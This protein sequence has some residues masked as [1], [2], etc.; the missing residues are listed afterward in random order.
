MVIETACSGALIAILNACNAMKQGQCDAAIVAGANILTHPN[1]SKIFNGLSMTSPTGYCKP[2]DDE[3]NGFVRSEAAEVIILQRECDAKRI[4]A[5][6]VHIAS[7]SDGFK[8]E[9]Y[10]YP[11][12]YRQKELFENFYNEINLNPNEVDYI[13]MHG[14]GTKAGDPVECWAVDQVFNQKR[15]KPLLIGS[16]KSNMGHTENF[17]AGASIAKAIFTFENGLIPPSIHFKTPNKN[18]PSL[19][20]GKLKVCTEITPLS[21]QY[22]AIN[23]FGFGGVNGHLLLK[24]SSKMKVNK[25]SPNDELPRL[26]LWSGR[27]KEAVKKMF[28]HIC[29]ETLDA[30]FVGLTHEI[31]KLPVY[32]HMNRGYGIF[33]NT[34]P[35][36][37][38]ISLEQH[39][40]KFDDIKRPIVWMLTG[41]GS[42]W[43]GMINGLMKIR[44]FR[45]TI[46]KCHKVLMEHNY[47]LISILEST[48]IDVINDIINSMVSIT[49]IE[50]GLIEILKMLN[51]P[52]DFVIGH[53]LGEVAVGYADESF[54]LEQTILCSYFR[55]LCSKK[56]QL[57]DGRM[58][59]IG[60][61]YND[62]KNLLPDR[63]YCACRNSSTSST[64][65]G[66]KS[67]IEKFVAELHSKKIFAK[68]VNTNNIA[69]HSKYIQ[70]IAELF[71]PK[72]K[73]IIPEPKKRSSKWLSTCYAQNEW[74]KPCA[75][76]L[77]AEYQV[78]NLL[79]TVL[80]EDILK[81]LP[82]DAIII[83][84]A[85]CG[86]LQA[87]VKRELPNNIHIPLLLK[88]SDNL[89]NLMKAFGK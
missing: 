76:Y 20:E 69:Y 84:I 44:I 49:A 9:G 25:G 54:T 2:F 60:L 83:E 22:Y 41:M 15:R 36:Q 77:N 42:Q 47:D 30:E 31:Q 23:S 38:A 86:L 68:E 57:I 51:I 12:K 89:L 35:A 59:A 7:N 4:Y 26:V 48:D 8:Q 37:N 82:K 45:E 43:L 1:M 17:S 34:G 81:I 32:G 85:P 87:I 46:E 14:T 16:I 11:S 56:A 58:Y 39:V 53:S 3:C 88:N 72:L 19:C 80:L 10:S 13:E 79:N 71:L 40:T 6:I 78:H 66:P 74:S 73:T 24:S 27:T 63:V 18:I 61:G 29:N 28:D 64:I 67:L 50:I 5:N 70:P 65:S 75:M 52:M 21:G 33:E 55:G 62:I